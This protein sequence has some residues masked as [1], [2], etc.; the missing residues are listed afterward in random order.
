MKKFT[1]PNFKTAVANDS[2][3]QT[4]KGST[5]GYLKLPKGMKMFKETEG[6][7]KLDIIPYVVTAKNHLDRNDDDGVAVPNSL[8]YRR[9]YKIH[10]KVGSANESI[11]CPTTF[12]RPCPICNYKKK[13]QAEGADWEEV[14][15]YNPKNRSL[16]CVIPIDEKKYDEELHLFDISDPCFQDQL[17]KD[18][19]EKENYGNFPDLEDGYTL[20]CRFEEKQLGKNKFIQANRINFIER[21]SVYD[22]E[23]IEDVPNLDEVLVEHTFEEIEAMFF[24]GEMPDNAGN[25]EDEDTPKKNSRHKKSVKKE[26][27]EDDD[28]PVK[29]PHKK[30][31]PLEDDEE[32]EDEKPTRR[33]TSVKEEPEDEEED[34]KPVKKLTRNKPAKKAKDEED[35]EDDE[36]PKS[37]LTQAAKKADPEDIC[38]ACKGTGVSSKGGECKP[39]KGT[40]V[41]INDDEDEEEDEKPAK[42]NPYDKQGPRPGKESS[43]SSSKKNQCPHGYEWGDADNH[44]KCDSCNLWDDCIEVNK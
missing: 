24:E 44:K 22:E 2:E 29:K 20:D 16:Y 42:K 26:D 3:R 30:F 27:D 17:N 33:R 15:E 19:K 11:V 12:G 1:K 25:D 8:W 41:I 40:G 13:R 23:I 43:K 10:R 21:E 4:Q 36:K 31:D 7:H 18:V 37:R 5:Y 38:K 39:C 9:P 6:K 35:E 32:E 14:K 28:E 34:E